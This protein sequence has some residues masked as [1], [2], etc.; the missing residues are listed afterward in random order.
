[1]RAALIKH[2][3]EAIAQ[4]AQ[5]AAAPD[6][7]TSHASTGYDP[8]FSFSVSEI[9][10]MFGALDDPARGAAA[11]VELAASVVPGSVGAAFARSGTTSGAQVIAVHRGCDLPAR[12]LNDLCNWAAG[13]FDVARTFDPEMRAARANWGSSGAIVTWRAKDVGYIGI[14]ESRA[15]AACLFSYVAERGIRT[16][17]VVLA[18][19]RAT[20]GD[21]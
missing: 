8:K 14:C 17:G 2:I 16:S 19:R 13:L 6:G 11:Q 12:E 21:A 3:G 7:F 4:L 20:D 10:A 5:A 18:A 1:L 15:A 9:L